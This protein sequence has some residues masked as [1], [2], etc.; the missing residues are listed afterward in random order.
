VT[1]AVEEIN[2]A[3]GSSPEFGGGMEFG[4]AGFVFAKLIGFPPFSPWCSRF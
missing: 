4:T 3:G 2:A 1:L